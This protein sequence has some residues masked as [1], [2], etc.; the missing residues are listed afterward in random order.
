MYMVH[1]LREGRT[2][3]QDMQSVGLTDVP[4]WEGNM[5][6]WWKAWEPIPTWVPCQE[7][8]GGPEYDLWT[9]NWKLLHL[10]SIL[11]ICPATFGCT[12]RSVH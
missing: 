1:L 11:A 2:L 6:F 12:R 7:F 10:P 4:G 3:R 9:V 8:D 5:D